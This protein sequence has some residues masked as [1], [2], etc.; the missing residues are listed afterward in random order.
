M[1]NGITTGKSATEFDPYGVTTRDQALTFLWRW[2]GSPA[3]AGSNTFTDVQSGA[4]YESAVNWAVENG[5]TTG[6]EDG[7]FGVELPCNRAHMITFLYRTI[8]D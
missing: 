6:L 5:I 7:T 1:E 4:W 8:G 3:A 2:M